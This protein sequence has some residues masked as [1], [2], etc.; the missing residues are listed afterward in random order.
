MAR[1]PMPHVLV[2][3]PGITGS[4][5]KKNGKV[6]WGF[7]GLSIGKILFTLGGSIRKALALPH[8]DPSVDDLGDGV[9]ADALMPDLHLLPGVWKIDGYSKVAD[10]LIATFDVTEGKNFFRFPYDWRRDNTVAARKLARESHDWLQRW[11]ESS[12]NRDAELILIGHSMGGIV[13]RYFLECL[14]GWKDTKALVTFGTPYRGSLNALDGFANGV[15]K[16]P[17]DLTD[18]I[19]ELTAMYQLLPIYECYDAGDGKLV[20]VGETAGIPGVDAA[21]AA[22]ALQFHRSIENAQKSNAALPQ[23][24]AKHYVIYPVVGL[25][26]ETNLSARSEHGRVTM[27]KTADGQP[28]GGDGTVPRVSAV[29]LELSTTPN[30][31]YA[32][33]QHGS[34]QNA[35]SV[36]EQLTGILS[37]MNIDLGSFKKSKTQIALEVEDVYYA[38]EPIAVRARPSRGEVALKVTLERGGEEALVSGMV[39]SPRDDWYSV[40]FPPQRPG[41]YR[42]G[43]TGD[44]V[45]PAEDSFAVS[46]VASDEV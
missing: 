43:V 33:T 12:G 15:R 39:R 46:E 41:A 27:L 23:Y 8:D 5:L 17:V 42:V 22:A 9:T 35:D 11:R 7:S 19:R 32:A 24:Q 1:I 37:G 25:S 31:M 29:P 38:D 34:L 4:V 26:Q 28:L 36:I 30:A 14:D 44:G 18:L 2:L 3:L 40:T 13:S 6:V 10:A 20:R 16:G 45:E 21:K